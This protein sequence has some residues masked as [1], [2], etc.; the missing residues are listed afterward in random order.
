MVEAV[1]RYGQRYSAIVS[2]IPL[3]SAKMNVGLTRGSPKI[4][5]TAAQIINILNG[6]ASK[7]AF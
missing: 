2:G 1:F 6:L 4:C 3:W 7:T 5:S